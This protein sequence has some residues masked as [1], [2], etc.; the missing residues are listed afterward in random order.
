MKEKMIKSLK[1][2]IFASIFIGVMTI[3][4]I[5]MMF[6][7]KPWYDELYTYYSFISRGPIYAAIHWPVPNNHVGYSVLSAC[8]NIFNNSYISLRGVSCIAS[9]AN[10]FLI[11][12]IGCYIMKKPYAFFSMVFYAGA[13]LVHTLSI[14]GR[15]YTLAVTCYL[16]AILACYKICIENAGKRYYI[17][18]T[19]SLAM[20]L[21][22]LP[23]SMYWVVP[24]CFIGGLF[25]LFKKNWSALLKLIVASLVAA[26]IT[27]FL[28]ALIWLAIGAN[29]MSKDVN[30]VYYGVYQVT[31]ILKAPFEAAKTGIKYMLA[32]PYIQSIDQ[33]TAILGMPAY[34]EQLF[35]QC[36]SYCGIA[37]EVL[38]LVMIVFYAMYSCM[39]FRY[40]RIALWN[41]ILLCGSL[42]LPIVMLLIQ[43][44]HPYKRVLSFMMVSMAL[45]LAYM[46]S[47]WVEHS[48]LNEISTKMEYGLMLI[49]VLI[50][51]YKFTTY[52]Y[53]RQLADREN[54]IEEALEEIDATKIDSIFYTDDYQKYV[55]KF[56]HNVE[57]AETEI[58]NANYTIIGS[59]IRTPQYV[60]NVW[61]VLMA[62]NQPFLKYV[63]DNFEQIV[64]T[65]KYVIYRRK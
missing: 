19:I 10:L 37:L 40:R 2:N 26:V 47:R 30:S 34:F 12:R 31:I 43:S 51:G 41:G 39:Q 35:S 48:D 24:I 59:E 28:Y 62:S 3:V 15:G 18:W 38:M 21:Y 22:I 33:R 20:G 23:S 9:V 4:Y 45:G 1:N 57:P 65:D 16:L 49:A 6:T 14:Q 42:L 29:L 8:L 25:L 50:V 53:T 46:L 27:F 17:M 64:E 13:N 58:E 60:E 44:V 32:T 5:V 63:D 54:D 55:L 61:P 36:Y 52:D 56:Y 7:N 11:Y